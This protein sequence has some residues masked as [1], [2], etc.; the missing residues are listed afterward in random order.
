MA[1]ARK[2]KRKSARRTP[3][4]TDTLKPLL[5]REVVLD[6]AGPVVFLGTLSEIRPDGYWLDRADIRDSAEG[7]VTKE[8]YVCE[9]RETGIRANRRRIFVRRDAVIS[10]SALADV[11][12]EWEKNE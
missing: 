10:L 3:R 7:H 11:V 5:G 1:A 2:Q 6:T 4:A 9:A 12:I 8:R